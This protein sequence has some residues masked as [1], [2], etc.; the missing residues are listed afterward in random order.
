M[1]RRWQKVRARLAVSTP[2]EGQPDVWS[3]IAAARIAGGPRPALPVHEAPARRGVVIAIIGGGIIALGA[4]SLRLPAPT[5]GL[6]ETTPT[7]FGWNWLIPPALAQA[8][9]NST[10]P[11]IDPLDLNRIRPG[12]R[13][14]ARRGGVDDILAQTSHS[15]TIEI[16]W[17]TAKSGRRIVAVRSV[18]ERRSVDTLVV[19]IEPPEAQRIVL[20]RKRDADSRRF[21]LVET[22]LR[23]D[24]VTLRVYPANGTA[25]SEHQYPASW[26]VGVEDVLS[27]LLP[28]VALRG[29]YARSLNYLDLLGGETRTAGRPYELRVVGREKVRTRAGSFDCWVVELK[30]LSPNRALIHRLMVSRAN[31]VLVKA[32]WDE[33]NGFF[34]EVE[35]LSA[36]P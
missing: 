32:R 7:E 16:F 22:V 35:L 28:G 5:T 21:A 26:A 9:G 25:V 23:P 2:V 14:Y 11:P 10:L 27:R 8:A 30:T 24:T 15:E 13:V 31:G 6:P 34:R 12:R 18:P 20:A 17:D 29:D 36:E 3:R 4:M 19:S 33:W 1:I